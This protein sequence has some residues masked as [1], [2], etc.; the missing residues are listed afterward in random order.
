VD[1]DIRDSSSLN[2]ALSYSTSHF[3]FSTF[4]IQLPDISFVV[5]CII[6]V[7]IVIS[8]NYCP[9]G[10]SLAARLAPSLNIPS[11]STI[12]KPSNQNSSKWVVAVTT[13]RL[14][15]QSISYSHLISRIFHWIFYWPS[16]HNVSITSIHDVTCT[17]IIPERVADGQLW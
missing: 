10:T 11:I 6:I 17:S 1:G 14:T 16:S 9:S 3:N 7:L 12:S 4:S 5:I 13:K 15:A 8:F 2:D